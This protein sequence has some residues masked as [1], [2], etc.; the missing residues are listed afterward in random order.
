MCFRLLAATALQ[1]LVLDA[2]PCP[3]I[4]PQSNNVTQH[5]N[6]AG[7][8]RYRV[9]AAPVDTATVV[10][11]GLTTMNGEDMVAD[12]KPTPIACP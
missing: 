3:P 8:E 4:F 10:H 7:V 11:E 2:R 1:A 9:P 5:T 12:P 6:I